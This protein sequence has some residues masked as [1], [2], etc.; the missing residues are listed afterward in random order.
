MARIIFWHFA[1]HN[2][3]CLRYYGLRLVQAEIGSIVPLGRGYFPHDSRHFVPGYFRAV[4]P[5][6]KPS[7][8]EVP[9]IIL[10]LMGIIPGLESCSPCSCGAKNAYV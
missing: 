7:P 10:A 2:T 4:P 8:I 6:Q 1:P 5:G 3:F 9:R